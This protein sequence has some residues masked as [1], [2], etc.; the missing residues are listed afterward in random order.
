[1]YVLGLQFLVWGLSGLYMVSTDIHAIHGDD[2][3]STK[4]AISIEQASYPV[5]ALLNRYPKAQEL[6]LTQIL[7]QAVVQIT[8]SDN[9]YR[10]ILVDARS[11]KPLAKFEA[12][13]IEAIARERALTDAPILSIN[14]LNEMPEYVA[15]RYAPAYE[16]RFDTW[17]NLTLFIHAGSGEIV[18]KRHSMWHIFDWMWRVHII[19]YDDGANVQ[20]WF[21]Q[22]IAS[23]G[24]IASALGI[25]LLWTRRR[26]TKQALLVSKPYYK[27]MLVAH[28]WIAMLVFVQLFVW[29]GSGLYLSFLSKPVFSSLPLSKVDWRQSFTA[30]QTLSKLLIGNEPVIEAKLVNV[31]GKPMLLY[32]Q[33][34]GYHRNFASTKGLLDINTGEPY[35]LGEGDFK[36]YFAELAIPINSVSYIA[37]GESEIR[38]EGNP[39]WK[40][41]KA[42]STHSYYFDA[43]SGQLITQFNTA[44]RVHDF[45]L[46]LHFMDYTGSGHF[47]HLWNIIFALALVF[48]SATGL[49]FTWRRIKL[50]SQR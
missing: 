9:P 26:F 48:L 32:T 17:D 40:V 33:S 16:V 41:S 12:P 11:A 34:E 27:H 22:V 10:V 25:A 14:L 13:Q 43:Q 15:A 6:K 28:K 47:N 20:N 5:Q 29:L 23:A 36:T 1:M 30:E 37:A 24:A 4:P 21:L 39:V 18:T 38:G 2:R 8:F 3:V 7:Q 44:K 50:Y 19:D 45:M 31:L 46:R 42:N 35:E 49:V